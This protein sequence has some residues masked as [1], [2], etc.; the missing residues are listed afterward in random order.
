MVTGTAIQART[1]PVV[2]PGADC[3]PKG[4]PEGRPGLYVGEDH[5]LRA[6]N[7]G[8]AQ[9]GLLQVRANAQQL[10]R[11]DGAPVEH[12]VERSGLQPEGCATVIV[13]HVL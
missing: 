5:R 11:R 7:H 3:P 2:E 9:N 6:L 8:V 12:G 4:V 13:H 1:I 10:V